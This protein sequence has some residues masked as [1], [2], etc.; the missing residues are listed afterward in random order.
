MKARKTTQATWLPDIALLPTPIWEVGDEEREELRGLLLSQKLPQ[1]R[2]IAAARGLAVRGSQREALVQALVE[3]LGDPAQQGTL[4]GE[5]GQPARALLALAFLAGEDE[6]PLT[7]SA[8]RRLLREGASGPAVEAGLA[9]LVELGLLLPNPD[10]VNRP[11]PFY[12]LPDAVAAGM[13]PLLPEA[14]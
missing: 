12:L 13:L 8:A 6:Q 2:A 14:R 1:L 9:R 4:V 10:G 3:S 5:L 11:D 7:Q